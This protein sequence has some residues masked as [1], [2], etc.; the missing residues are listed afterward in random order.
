VLDYRSL[1]H[2]PPVGDRWWGK[3]LIVGT[4]LVRTRPGQRAPSG[5]ERRCGQGEQGGVGGTAAMDKPNNRAALLNV[6]SF[7]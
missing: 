5:Q 3:S 6:F 2:P 1:V 7:P 4:D